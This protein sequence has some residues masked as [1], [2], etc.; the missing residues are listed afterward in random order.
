MTIVLR[1]DVT[2]PQTDHVLVCIAQVGFRPDL[3][4]GERRAIIGVIG[5]ESRLQATP[6]SATPGVEQVLPIL[7]PFKLASREMQ[8][9]DSVVEVQAGTGGV[10]RTVKVGGGH[11]AMIA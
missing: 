4:R 1:P 6:L 10:G 3:S 9:G 8:P 2:E 5:D 11:L 7:K